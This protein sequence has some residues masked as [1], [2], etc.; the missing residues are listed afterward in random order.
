MKGFFVAVGA[1]L[2]VLGLAWVWRYR[3]A[4]GLLVQYPDE[5][6]KAAQLGSGVSDAITALTH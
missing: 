5:L 1:G 6:N 3:Y 4:V 2:V